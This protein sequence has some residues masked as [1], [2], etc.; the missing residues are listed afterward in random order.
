MNPQFLP[1]PLSQ[2]DA[3][4]KLKKTNI[5]LSTATLWEKKMG[6]ETGRQQDQ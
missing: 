4:F 5:Q 1:V 2:V 6:D 3:Y